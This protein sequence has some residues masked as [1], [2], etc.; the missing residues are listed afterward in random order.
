MR[1]LGSLGNLLRIR[2]DFEREFASNA[3]CFRMVFAVNEVVNISLG[4]RSHQVVDISCA[5]YVEHNQHQS[6]FA[7][8]ASHPIRHPKAETDHQIKS[9]PSYLETNH[10]K[11]QTQTC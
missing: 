4:H 6:A 5:I 11:R 1:I 8:N 10:L 3:A 9:H 2:M 7:D